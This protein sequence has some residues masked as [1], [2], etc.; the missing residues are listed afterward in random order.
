MAIHKIKINNFK[1]FNGVF[2]LKLNEGLNILVGNNEA[3]KSTILQAIHLALTGFYE[4]RNIKSELS[5]YLFNREVVER[6]IDSVNNGN[7]LMPPSIN[8]EI[9]FNSSINP[10]FE[11]NDNS[12]YSSCEGLTFQIAFDE[13]YIEEYNTLISKKDMMSLPIEYYEATWTTFA[14]Q[15]ITTR[16]IPIKSAMIDSANY[17]YQNGSD[18][19][20][21][22]GLL[23]ICFL[24]KK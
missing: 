5:Q 11:G 12:E 1:C 10:E 8:I 23:R 15:T 2:E 20:I 6:Y 4:G 24:Q 13:K 17:R 22:L 18:I 21:Y 3:G 14:R 16:S 19:Y 9:F 7:A